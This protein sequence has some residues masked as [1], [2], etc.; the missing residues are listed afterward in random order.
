MVK[1]WHETQYH[2]KIV[3]NN[4]VYIECCLLDNSLF[5]YANDVRYFNLLLQSYTETSRH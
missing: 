2:D 3:Y 4:E 1:Q 5:F